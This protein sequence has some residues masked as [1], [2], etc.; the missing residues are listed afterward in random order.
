MPAGL[1][2]ERIPV[3]FEKRVEQKIRASVL[4]QPEPIRL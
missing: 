1:D 4:I 2:P 3:R